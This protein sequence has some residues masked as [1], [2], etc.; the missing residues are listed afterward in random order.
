MEAQ[1]EALI[2][3]GG[4]L[5]KMSEE[6]LTYSDSGVDIAAAESALSSVG[7][8]IKAT[9]G[10]EV[11]SGVG[12]FGGVFSLGE[13][14][15]RALVSSIDGVGTKTKVAA[16]AGDYSGIGKDIVNHCVN[17]ILCQG[18][19]PLFFLDY[20]GCSELDQ[21]AFSQVVRGAA[22]ACREAGCALIGGETA[23]MPGV[24]TDG[25][26]DVVGCIVG[27]VEADHRI[28]KSASVKSGDALI[29]IAS[30]G[31]HTNGFSLARRALFEK[32][33][34]SVR[35]LLKDGKTTIAEAL[36]APHRCYV[37][38][39]LPLIESGQVLA[40]AHI[41]GGGITGNL[42]RILPGSL[43]ARINRR[44]WETPEI[45]E[46][47][48]NQGGISD[49]EMHVAF[50]MGIGMILVVGSEEADHVTESLNAAGDHAA[51]IGRLAA[52]SGEVSIV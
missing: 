24:Y 29:G 47:I 38:S 40:A 6:K 4:K 30:N 5:A 1:P 26:V 33:G 45:F 12:G 36:L 43:M 2:L 20:F 41:T 44:S 31:L 16:M 35:D 42:S 27:A 10:P 22:D 9:H 50:N 51:I 18:A 19:K 39:V 15:S 48:Q 32:G 7:D 13:E 52:G 3:S 46:L 49:D 8:A 11:L 37:N 17:D 14:S 21:T 23:E 25:E 28:P 34:L